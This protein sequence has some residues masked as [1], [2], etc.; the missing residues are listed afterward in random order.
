MATED[1]QARSRLIL[2]CAIGFSLLGLLVTICSAMMLITRVSRRAVPSITAV[3]GSIRLAP[4]TAE[5]RSRLVE[6]VA[7]PGETAFESSADQTSVSGN[8]ATMTRTFPLAAGSKF[9]VKNMIGSISVEAWD[10]PRAE[11]KLIKRGPG[12]GAR[13]FFVSSTNDLSLRTEAPDGDS[14][15]DIRYEVK[16]PRDMGRV[17]LMA[18]IGSVKLSGVTAKISVQNAN[19]SIELNDV[20]GVS[21][22]QTTN[23]KI[24][25]TLAGASDGPMEFVTANGRID[26]TIKG[27]FAAE[28]D[29]STVHGGIN[30]DDQLGIPVKKEM[31]GQHARGQ[32]G[33]GGPALKLTAINGSVKLSKQQ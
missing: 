25:A 18:A 23:G 11:V 28:L 24:N 20:V 1:W 15:Q 14:N 21:R 7:Q 12:R 26:V 4:E 3:S 10:L 13:V 19:G 16:I 17:E 5:R 2:A 8:G 33:S 29:A 32:I 22:V 31:V 27:D 6:P 30:I 9:S